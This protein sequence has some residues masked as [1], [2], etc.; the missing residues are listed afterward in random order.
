MYVLTHKGQKVT[1][2]AKGVHNK[3]HH[4]VLLPEGGDHNEHIFS[5]APYGQFVDVTPPLPTN[6]LPSLPTHFQ[7]RG[8]EQYQVRFVVVLLSL[9]IP[10][11]HSV[12]PFLQ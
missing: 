7:K 12:S 1:G 5:D 6:L 3:Q 2:R 8:V 11:A 9:F 10:S 4:F